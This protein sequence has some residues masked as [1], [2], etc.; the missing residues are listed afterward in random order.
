MSYDV[1]HNQPIMNFG[2]VTPLSLIHSL[3]FRPYRSHLD[4][5]A[6]LANYSD[7]DKGLLLATY[8][9]EE[10]GGSKRPSMPPSK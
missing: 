8:G 6:R 1:Y 4:S 2:Q 7:T 10:L 3:D 9:S 5:E